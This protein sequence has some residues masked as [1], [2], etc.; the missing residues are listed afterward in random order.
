MT[1]RYSFVAG[2]VGFFGGMLYRDKRPLNKFEIF[3]ANPVQPVVDTSEHME[4]DQSDDFVSRTMK[5]GF[6]GVDTIRSRKSFVLSY[7]RRNRVPHWVFEHLTTEHITPNENVNKK[8]C[9]FFEDDSIHAYF[10]STDDDYKG[11]GFDRGHLAAASNHRSKQEYLDDTFVLSNIAP[12]VGKGFNQDAWE[13]LEEHVKKL[14]KNYKNVYVCT[15]PL[16][17]PRFVIK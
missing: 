11:S 10:R 6:P 3:A 12:Q 17:I 4:I 9:E 2:A 15:G 5:F 8:K 7:D 14:V 16:Y 1:M 13:K